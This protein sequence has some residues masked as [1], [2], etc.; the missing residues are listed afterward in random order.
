[1][2]PFEGEMTCPMLGKM[3]GLIIFFARPGI[4][5]IVL[6]HVLLPM[7]QKKMLLIFANVCQWLNLASTKVK[8]S[9]THYF[10]G[11]RSQKIIEF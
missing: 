2:Y 7:S 8:L 6:I 3:A 1:M 4:L 5:F 10:K 11:I 9:L